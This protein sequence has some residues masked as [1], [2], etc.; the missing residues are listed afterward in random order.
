MKASDYIISFLS[1]QGSTKIF[2]LSG[3]MI[4]HLEDSVFLSEKSELIS[5]KHEQA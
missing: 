2:S 5:V 4:T 3:G 1:E